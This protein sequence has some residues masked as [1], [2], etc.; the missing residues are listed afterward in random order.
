[1][2]TFWRSNR[3]NVFI[4]GYNG[5]GEAGLGHTD[6]I[7]QLTE[8]KT[9]K[10]ITK[11]YP[12]NL[13]TIYTDDQFNN[14]LVSGHNKYGQLGVNTN[15]E[16]ITTLT[17]LTFFKDNNIKIKNIFVSITAY[18]TFFL[19][20]DNKVYGCGANTDDDLGLENKTEP[21]NFDTRSY[22]KNQHQPVL[23]STLKDVI[24]IRGSTYYSIALC[25]SD[26]T[27]LT[28]IINHWCRLYS[29][30]DDI[31]SL[32]LMFTKYSKVYST[33]YNRRHGHG[34]KYKPEQDHLL[35]FGWR[36]IE[37]LSDKHIIKITAGYAHSLFLGADG[38]VY[39]CGTNA[40][41]ESGLGEGVAGTNTP[42]PIEYFIKNGIR[43]VDIAAGCYH[44]L[45]LDDQGRIYGFGYNAKAQCGLGDIGSVRTP[46]LIEYLKEYV[47]V[48]IKCG[49]HMSYCKT[50]CGKNF[51]WGTNDDNECM[52][53]KHQHYKVAVPNKIDDIVK[54]K[55]GGKSI[56]SVHPGYYCTKLVVC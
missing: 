28:K 1:M 25:S 27:K 50:E 33:V 30:P 38:V 24:E 53:F 37:A 19:T 8:I 55:C 12:S 39:S 44:N 16:N 3:P 47:V 9:N 20:T 21:E 41:G 4:I 52:K 40:D 31:M 46:K 54:I 26:D 17:P 34:D 56:V 2:S 43:I 51:L 14:I 45:V 32:L 35:Y 49:Q 36:E 6:T 10:L 7:K 13:N 29:I 15:G 48:E 22:L 23:I 18:T 42:T 11:I 5:N